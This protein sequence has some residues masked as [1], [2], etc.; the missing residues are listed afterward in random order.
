M[1]QP[2]VSIVCE[3]YNHKPYLRR[4]LDG[5][6]MQKTD[7]PFE[8]VI[9]D[10]ASPD[11]SAEIIREYEKDYPQLFNPIYQT[12]NQYSKGVQL[13]RTIQFPRARGKYIAICEGD[14]YWTDPLKLQKQVDYLEKETDCGLCFTDYSIKDEKNRLIQDS[15]FLNGKHRSIDFEDHLFSQGYIAPRTWVFRKEIYEQFDTP[16]SF[17]DGSFGLAL[18]FFHHGKVAFLKDNT[19]VHVIHAGSATH[20]TDPKKHFNY[21]FDVVKEQVFYAKKYLGDS[22][23]TSIC[24]D[25]YLELLPMAVEVNNVEFLGI[26][27]S[28]FE[29]RGAKFE[30]LLQHAE[31]IL[32]LRDDARNA[33]M[34]KAYRLGSVILRPI[35]FILRK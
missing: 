21:V 25:K 28:F 17:I 1:C 20:Q 6:V 13:W 34:S 33:R 9:H 26:A 24:F 23:A 12:E 15:C 19:A 27:R 10:D 7:F 4:C 32:G 22:A 18:E 14:D 2:L 11:G 3:V 5:F 16:P 29:E 35:K 30:N 31:M 8:I